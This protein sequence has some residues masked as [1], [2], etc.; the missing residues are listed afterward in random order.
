MERFTRRGGPPPDPE[1][2]PGPRDPDRVRVLIEYPREGTPTVLADVLTRA[3][4]EPLVC[5]GPSDDPASCR[6]LRNG[7]CALAAGA[8]VIFNGFGLGAEQ[9]RHIIS[10]L[11]AAHPDTPLIV[12]ATR[13]RADENAD[14][15]DGCRRC[16]WPLTA[17]GFVDAVRDA[18]EGAN[19][20][21]VVPE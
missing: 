7:E 3:G 6:L 2:W 5:Q 1:R 13:P 16:D 12:E 9:H 18:A 8:D 15:L 10:E 20:R 11:R 21:G 4:Y 14:L 17:G 19:A